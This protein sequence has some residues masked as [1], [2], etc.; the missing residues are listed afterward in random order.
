MALQ[1]SC[2]SPALCLYLWPSPELSKFSKTTFTG[3]P[4]KTS[5]LLANLAACSAL[6]IN[7]PFILHLTNSSSS[8]QL[9]LYHASARDPHG[10]PTNGGE[11]KKS[12]VVARLY[13]TEWE[14]IQIFTLLHDH[15]EFYILSSSAAGKSQL[16]DHCACYLNPSLLEC[17]TIYLLFWY[18]SL[19]SDCKS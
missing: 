12:G 16:H 13:I 15:V 4:S 18:L 9:L 19:I 5:P 8:E 10:D 6:L 3:S 14:I 7:K 2:H 1:V 11:E 17:T